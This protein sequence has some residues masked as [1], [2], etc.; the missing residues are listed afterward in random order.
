MIPPLLLGMDREQITRMMGEEPTASASR[1]PDEEVLR[2]RDA[3]VVLRD[4]RAVEVSLS[5]LQGSCSKARR[6]LRLGHASSLTND[7]VFLRLPACVSFHA[8]VG[9]PPIPDISAEV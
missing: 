6:C 9:S 4:G 1:L 2:Y 7:G 8:N 3:R 5:L